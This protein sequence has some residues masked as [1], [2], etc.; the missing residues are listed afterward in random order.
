MQFG[1]TVSNVLAILQEHRKYDAV[2]KLVKDMPELSIYIIIYIYTVYTY[3]YITK[4]IDI[5]IDIDR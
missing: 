5:D 2:M 1:C 4:D 3:V